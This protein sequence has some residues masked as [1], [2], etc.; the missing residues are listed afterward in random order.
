MGF[1]LIGEKEEVYF[2]NNVWWWRRLAD[3][4]IYKTGVVNKE[5]HEL[6]HY[7]D[8]HLVTK[9]EAEQI[10]NQL[11]FLMKRGDVLE[12]ENEVKKNMIEASKHNKRIEKVREQLRKRVV[13]EVGD[14]SIV[15]RDY[16]EPYKARWDKLYELQD[17]RDSYPF[18]Q[19]NVEE[20]IEFCRESDGFRIC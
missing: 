7:N 18:S 17:H 5:H 19:K 20:F 2:R 4:V 8:G 9:E 10:A 1:D 15:P 11:E 12:F 13:K 3:F 14:S 16:P 6:W